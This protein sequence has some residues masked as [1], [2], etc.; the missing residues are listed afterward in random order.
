MN[1]NIELETP[2][3]MAVAISRGWTPT[4]DDTSVEMIGDDY[5][6]KENPVSAVQFLEGYLPAFIREYVLTEGRKNV[7]NG[8]E[9]ISESIKHRVNS[10]DFDDLIL[11]GDREAISDIVRESL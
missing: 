5:Q 6:Q 8:F 3:L 2:V 4:I 9:S 7:I 10:G 11:I 1:V